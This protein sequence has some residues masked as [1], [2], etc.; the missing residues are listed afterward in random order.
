MKELRDPQLDERAVTATLSNG[1]PVCVVP[2]PGFAKKCAYFVT[3]YGSIDTKFTWRGP[4][5]WIIRM[6]TLW[7]RVFCPIRI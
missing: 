2:K 3:N 7:N 4:A 5:P 6:R 1:L